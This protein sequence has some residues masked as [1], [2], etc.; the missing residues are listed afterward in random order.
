MIVN[1]IHTQVSLSKIL[2]SN[3]SHKGYEEGS[4]YYYKGDDARKAGN[5]QEAIRL[6]DLAR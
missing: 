3:D 6:L 1:P 5:L 4:P 2:N